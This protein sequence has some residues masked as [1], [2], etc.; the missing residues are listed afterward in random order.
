MTAA[1]DML[2]DDSTWPDSQHAFQ[3]SPPHSNCAGHSLV[4]CPLSFR[5]VRPVQA[6][7]AHV[8]CT[9]AEV[10]QHEGRKGRV[11]RLTTHATLAGVRCKL[12]PVDLGMCRV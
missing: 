9:G 10:T 1:Y 11:I 12:R 5:E 4:T 8:V 6:Q 3:L 2:A 7:A